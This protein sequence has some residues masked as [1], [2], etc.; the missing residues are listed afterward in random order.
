MRVWLDDERPMPPDFNFHVKTAAEAIV[1]LRTGHI[2]AISLD[3]DLGP[4]VAEGYT[5]ADYIEK[6]AF[7]GT[8]QKLQ[9][10]VHTDNLPRREYIKQA[11][12]NAMRYW[13]ERASKE[14]SDG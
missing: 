1:F 12:R 3:N 8:L 10:Y 7:D 2:T 11:F 9:L 4:G 6:A 14:K 5:V 13:M